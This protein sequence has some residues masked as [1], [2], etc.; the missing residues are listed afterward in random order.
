MSHS[1]VD[2]ISCEFPVLS[3]CETPRVSALLFNVLIGSLELDLDVLF[4]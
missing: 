4:E 3:V 2:S 1:L